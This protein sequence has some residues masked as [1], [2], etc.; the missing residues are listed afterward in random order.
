MGVMTSAPL[1]SSQRVAASPSMACNGGKGGRGGMGPKKDKER[2]GKLKAL[3]QVA[4]S[5]EYAKAVLLSSQTEQLILKM[6]WR[7]RRSAKHHVKKRA[8][9]F[10]VD[11]PDGFAGFNSPK[12]ST[13]KHLLSPSI[14]E[15]SPTSPLA[16]A[17]LAKLR[18]A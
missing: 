4:D 8:A 12:L 16:A 13:K 10:D 6:N 11:I 15:K 2:R 9:Q 3:I 5:T 17:A 18:A 1:H 14:N 7:L